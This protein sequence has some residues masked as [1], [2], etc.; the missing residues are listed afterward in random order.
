MMFEEYSHMILDGEDDPISL[1]MVAGMIRNDFPWLSEIIVETY[2]D[3]KNG[4]AKDAEKAVHRL[5]R[6]TKMMRE[7][8]FME[9]FMGGSKEAHMMAMELPRFFNRTLRRY[10]KNQNTESD[11]DK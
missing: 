5:L 7:E 11:D 8:P 2:R 1:L 9:E 4:K 10:T 6:S 3:I